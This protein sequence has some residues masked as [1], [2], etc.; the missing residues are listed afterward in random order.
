MEP[1]PISE[2]DVIE[3]AR[4]GRRRR[5]TAEEKRKIVEETAVPGQNVL[6]VSRWYGVS[7]SQVSKWRRLVE[8]GTMS[9]LGADEAGVPQSEAKALKGRIGK[10]ERLL[11]RKTLKNEILKEVIKIGRERSGGAPESG[12]VSTEKRFRPSVS[13]YF[14]HSYSFSVSPSLGAGTFFVSRGASFIVLVCPSANQTRTMH[15]LQ[16]FI[17]R[18]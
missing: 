7:P 17:S 10:L 13:T 15:L 1:G 9:S 14:G 4:P 12:T 5:F 8:E 6:S 18:F 16:E 3:P 11:G 2:V